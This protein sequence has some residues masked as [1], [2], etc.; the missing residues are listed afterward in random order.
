MGAVKSHFHDEIMARF[1]HDYDEP[2]ECESCG[3][4]FL[5]MQG[6]TCSGCAQ[7]ANQ[8]EHDHAA[9]YA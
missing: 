5:G 6:E 9:V 3:R 8:E 2:D 1:D 4:M 7:S